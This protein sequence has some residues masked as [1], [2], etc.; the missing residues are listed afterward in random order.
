MKRQGFTLLEMLIVITIMIFL[1]TISVMNYFGSMR[2]A[3]YT[4]VSNNVFS[5]LLM[6]RQRACV[7]NKQV[8]LMLVNATNYAVYSAIGEVTAI[9]P[10]TFGAPSG[11]MVLIDEYSDLTSWTLPTVVNMSRPQ[12]IASVYSAGLSR[13]VRSEVNASGDFEPFT[14]NCF[15]IHAV[16]SGEWTE[17]DRYGIE[18][19]SPQM[20]PKGFVFDPDTMTLPS[21]QRVVLF[22]EDGTCSGLERIVVR[23]SSTGNR[24]EFRIDP[25]GKVSQR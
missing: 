17:G 11:G 15:A 10:D 25:N 4:T 3:G 13:H 24:I 9:V 12:S 18:V 8:M 6:A 20:L 1:T 19:F 7:D 21:E 16:L 5:A 2:A 14:N 22:A 23:E